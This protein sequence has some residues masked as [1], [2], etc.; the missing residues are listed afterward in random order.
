MIEY[1]KD[2]PGHDRRYAVDA[3]KIKEELGWRPKYNFDEALRITVKWYQEHADWWKK[4]KDRDFEKY[5]E[6]QYVKR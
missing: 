4:L 5:Y 3:T 6:R 2:R 1:V